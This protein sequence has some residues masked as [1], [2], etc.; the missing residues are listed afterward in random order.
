MPA[1]AL[2]IGYLSAPD[3][4]PSGRC[5]GMGLGCVPSPKDSVL[6]V[7]FF[8]YPVCVLAGLLAMGVIAWT[9]SLR[10]RSR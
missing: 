4:N 2:L 9:R 5:E 6:F 1:V 7:A 10:Q 3:H 8:G